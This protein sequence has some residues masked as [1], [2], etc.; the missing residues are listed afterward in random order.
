LST[1]R[2]YGTPE[3]R[4]WAKVNKTE[5]CWLWTANR[6]RS[7]YGNF[8]YQNRQ[9][10]AH[11]T[12][13]EWLVGPIPE[14][15]Q[16][17]HLCRVR[18]CVNPEHL[19]PTTGKVNTLRGTGP[20]ALNAVKT[21][22]SQDHPLDGDNLYTWKNERGCR[23][24]RASNVKNYLSRLVEKSKTDPSLIP[25]GTLNGYANWKCRCVDCSLVQSKYD[26]AYKIRKKAEKK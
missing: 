23:S 26:A 9:T 15:L 20:S 24:C 18:H 22:C 11:R 10:R 16:L 1:K 3:E 14:G 19:E 21:H 2:I 12:A 4:F 7:G 6:G 8:R 25:H 17:D 5:T 13:Y